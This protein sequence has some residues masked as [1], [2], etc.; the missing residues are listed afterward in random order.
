L[1]LVVKKLN[2]HLPENP[3]YI[4]GEGGQFTSSSTLPPTPSQSLGILVQHVKNQGQQINN[5][6]NT[7]S[8]GKSF[9]EILLGKLLNYISSLIFP[10]LGPIFTALQNDPAAV[11]LSAANVA[12]SNCDIM[13]SADDQSKNP[14]EKQEFL[15]SL[16]NALLKELLRMLLVFVIREFKT[17]VANYFARTAIEKQKRRANK[18]KQKFSIFDAAGGALDTA[19]KAAKYA[20][21][22]AALATILGTIAST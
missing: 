1:K 2:I 20:A 18:V 19:T 4:F 10:F 3:G 17:L 13:N 22:V 15:R 6:E 5:E 7:N 9:F 14:K 8:I 16:A 11:G 21:A 12:Y